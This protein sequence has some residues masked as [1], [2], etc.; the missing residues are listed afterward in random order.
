MIEPAQTKAPKEVIV[1]DT[2]KK[3][4]DEIL[5]IIQKSDYNIV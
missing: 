4:M 1:E 5:K 3:E 2:S